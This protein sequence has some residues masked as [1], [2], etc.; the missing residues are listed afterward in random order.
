[1]TTTNVPSQI[2]SE[3]LFLCESTSDLM[4]CREFYIL[5]ERFCNDIG[6]VNPH[7]DVF[8]NQYF[9]NDGYVDIWR[10]PHLMIG[11]FNQNLKFHKVLDCDEFRISFHQFLTELY[12]FCLSECQSSLFVR[13]D[14]SSSQIT[15]RHFK[16]R[17]QFLNTLIVTFI[18]VME[19]IE[20]FD[21]AEMKV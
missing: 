14:P 4:N 12:N 3:E 18:N 2:N 6:K 21:K 1:M 7:Y 20:N 11:S 8:L 16:I 5:L 19:N 9:N 15:V 17:Q 10:I 13:P